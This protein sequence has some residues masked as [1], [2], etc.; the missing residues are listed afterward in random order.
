MAF[1]KLSP[2]QKRALFYLRELGEM[3]VSPQDA[4]SLKILQKRGLIRYRRHDG[5]RY[6]VLRTWEKAERSRLKSAPRWFGWNTEGKE[7]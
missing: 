3:V 1:K 4:R 2:A 7:A 5:V 6:A